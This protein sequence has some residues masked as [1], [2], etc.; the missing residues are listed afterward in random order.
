MKDNDI[1]RL[2]AP[3]RVNYIRGKK[4][5]GCIFCRRHEEPRNYVIFKTKHALAMLNIF[6]YNNGHIM[7]APLRHLDSLDKLTDTEAMGLFEAVKLAQR[8][9][10]KVVKPQG[11]NIGINIGKTAGAGIAGHLHI[12]IVP[13]WNGDTNFMPTIFKTKVISEALDSLCRQL[14]NAQEKTT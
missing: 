9:L 10:D 11:Y 4:A 13:R 6:P 12:H 5:S 8:L 1:D 3:W 14:K 7:I 2:W